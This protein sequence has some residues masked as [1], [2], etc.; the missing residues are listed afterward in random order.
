MTTDRRP[1]PT[2]R[3]PPRLRSPRQR[4]WD[5]LLVL[6]PGFVKSEG[7]L[8]TLLCVPAGMAVGYGVALAFGLPPILGLMIGAMPAFITCLVIVDPSAGRVAGRTGAVVVPFVAALAGS[9]ALHPYR[10]LELVLIVVLLFVQF[11]AFQWGKWASDAAIVA[12][13]GYLCGL[14]L[15]LPGT[16]VLPLSL[17]VA[18]SLVATIVIRTGFLRPDA[19]RSLLRTRRG[20]LARGADVLE[21][22][23]AALAVADDSRARSRALRRLARR[24]SHHH[25]IALTVDGMLA[26]SGGDAADELHRLVF[27]T[28][29]AID[30]L[31]R[32]AATLVEQGAPEDV[33]HAALRAITIVL[34]HGGSA[35]DDAGRTLAARFA[36]TA[37]AADP[38]S[39]T[40]VLVHRMAREFADLRTAGLRWRD[41]ADELPRSGDG[42][43]FASPVILA[44]GRPAGAV[45]VVAD[46]IADGPWRRLHMTASLRTAVHAAIA[47]AITEPL[48]LLLDGSRFYW[49]V[50]GVMIVLAGTNTT[51]ERIRKGIH[52]GV[53]TI[54]GG[55][56]GIALVHLLGTDHPW[57]T[58][59]LVCVLLAVGTYG[60]S[61][62][63]A[64]WAACLVVVLCQVYDFSGT[65]TDDLIPIRLAENLLGAAIAILVSVVVL[66]LAT[67]SVVRRAVQ[68]QLVAVRAFVLAAVGVD[69]DET[70][71][72][73]AAD[74]TRASGPTPDL[75]ARSRAVDAATYQLEAV[76]KPMVRF[77]T[78]G[79]ARADARMRA[80]LQA[81]ATFARELAG[82]PG[83]APADVPDSL[84]GAAEALAASVERL[85]D[86]IM[87]GAA[88]AAGVAGAP[89]A[90]ADGSLAWTRI[91][92]RLDSVAAADE[93]DHGD[94]LRARAYALGRID[95]ALALFAERIGMPVV[96]GAATRMSA[97]G[98]TIST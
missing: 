7:A 48:A 41:V 84:R 85:A 89:D 73:D 98:G 86:R 59:V 17:V 93:G 81:A 58:I 66:P 46:A 51:H 4:L 47:V 10:I 75:R 94:A 82:R 80:S 29:F 52:R 27:D 67:R 79:P 77:P 69:V 35:G 74:P 3:L 64:V 63:Y 95:E 8:R 78:G 56:V 19:Y 70:E 23:A 54:V 55:V 62:V 30:E 12:F 83:A 34:R 37:S 42:V 96:A 16:S 90:V 92:D 68:R 5:R 22:A 28:H 26:A 50:I 87:S 65:F 11:L 88:S 1:A 15:P 21:A 36:I 71:S 2:H 39:R 97:V 49:G 25:E 43:P 20:F 76:L 57:V 72:A 9:I 18:A 61:G 53:G 33:R 38:A 24:R 44:G 32:A 31:G 13:A 45:P 40:T 6:D 91:T 60:F 14:L